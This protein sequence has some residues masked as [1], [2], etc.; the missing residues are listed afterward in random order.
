[1]TRQKE[2]HQGRDGNTNDKATQHARLRAHAIL[3]SLVLRG[4]S[5]KYRLAL[6]LGPRVGL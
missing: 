2:K 1:V 5:R 4:N 3:K 6:K